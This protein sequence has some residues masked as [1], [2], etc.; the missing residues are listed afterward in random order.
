MIVP[1]WLF[2]HI[3]WWGYSWQQGSGGLTRPFFDEVCECGVLWTV[4]SIHV[5]NDA[6][7]WLGHI[8]EW[9]YL[10]ISENA[11]VSILNVDEC[12]VLGGFFIQ[13]VSKRAV[14][15]WKSI[16][17]YTED[18]HNVSNCHNVAKHCKFDARGTVVSNTAT[19]SAPALEKF[20]STSTPVSQVGGLVGGADSMATSFPGSYS[21]GFFL[22]GIP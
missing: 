7:L 2:H 11:A 15:L 14:Q 8:K 20:A 18:I 9:R 3:M 22:M 16:Q 13:S 12:A 5:A 19:A 4:D 6:I 1:L 17:I 10:D 21:P